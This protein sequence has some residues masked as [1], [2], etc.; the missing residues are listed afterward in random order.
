[1]PA[2]PYPALYQINTRVHLAELSAG[3][4]RPA[5]L[6]DVPNT[7]LDRLQRLGFEWVWLLSVWQTGQAGQRISRTNVDWRKEFLV[8]LPDLR[9]ED[10]AG[11]GFAVTAYTVNEQLGGDAALGRLRRRMAER[12]IKLMLDFV[13]NHV[14]LDHPWVNHYPDFFIEGTEDDL[15]HDPA[16]YTKIQTGTG[17]RIFA[18]GRDPNFPGWPDTLQLNYA[19]WELQE[20]MTRELIHVSDHCDG[21]RCDMAMLMCPGVFERTWGKRPGP[22]WPRA[23]LRA[24]DHHPG[25]IVMAEVYWD[26]EWE[27]QQQ[28]FDFTYDKRLYDRLRDRKAKPIRDHFGASMDYQEKLVRF[29]ENHD[30]ARAAATFSREEHE[31]AALITFLSPG[32]RLVHEG[33]LEGKKTHVPTHLVRRPTE[34]VDQPLA[35]FY[36]TLLE[37]LK[38]PAFHTGRWTLL[39]CM[40]AWGGNESNDYFVAFN[41]Q[42]A[43]QKHYIVAVNYSGERAQCFVKLPF[44]DLENKEWRLRDLFSDTVFDRDG[45]DLAARGLFLDEKAWKYYVFELV[46]KRAI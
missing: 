8:T 11:S 30:E 33:Q 43:R 23:L 37:T 15:K 7:E 5:T 2:R 6:D 18:H 14:A 38:L 3:L 44:A 46:P 35:D 12:N 4:G 42:D 25:F 20:A 24:K 41:W 34:P 13:P 29:L 36:A 21:V 27:L 1:M 22:F 31:A 16:N 17:E 39:E 10:I 26:M 28:G 19:S 32:L 9:D 45:N 40:P